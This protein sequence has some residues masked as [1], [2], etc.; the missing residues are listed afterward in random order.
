MAAEKDAYERR[1]DG[2][3]RVDEPEAVLD[4][5][6]E[7][8]ANG[9]VQEEED[10]DCKNGVGVSEKMPK[11]F[12]PTISGSPT[13]GALSVTA[14]AALGCKNGGD[15]CHSTEQH[16]ADIPAM[17]EMIR[18]R[19]CETNSNSKRFTVGWGAHADETHPTQDLV[20]HPWKIQSSNED[21]L[22]KIRTILAFRAFICA[23]MVVSDW[24]KCLV[25]SVGM[26]ET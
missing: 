26:D 1:K 25:C 18:M 15:N 14:Q 12:E 24:I 7:P 21:H 19:K 3:V 2:P 4:E 9:N 11:W 22:T 8:E 10:V 16:V 6:D 5:P 20:H 13:G 23:K 17:P